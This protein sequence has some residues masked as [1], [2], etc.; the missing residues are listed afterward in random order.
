M[1]DGIETLGGPAA[2]PRV[3]GELS[4]EA[5]WQSRLFGLTAVLVAAGVFGWRDLQQALIGAIAERE[6]DPAPGPTRYWERWRVAVEGLLARRGVCVPDEI[7]TRAD[8]LSAR[9][10][11]H[12]HG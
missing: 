5:P 12:D 4:F 11:G 10:P 9:P 3:N 2:P 7:A 1:P 8:R 6:R